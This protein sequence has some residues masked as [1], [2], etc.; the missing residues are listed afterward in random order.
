LGYYTVVAALLKAKTNPNG[1][2]LIAAAENNRRGIVQLLLESN[3]PKDFP[4]SSGMTAL[5]CA[6]AQG[7]DSIVSLLLEK[8]AD[9]ELRGR[10]DRTALLEAVIGGHTATVEALLR[11]GSDFKAQDIG[12]KTPVDWAIEKQLTPVLQLLA[13]SGETVPGHTGDGTN[14]LAKK[15]DLDVPPQ[16]P[17][18]ETS[19]TNFKFPELLPKLSKLYSMDGL[20]I[21][22][23]ITGLDHPFKAFDALKDENYDHM[24]QS[25]GFTTEFE[26]NPFKGGRPEPGNQ[27]YDLINSH[28]NKKINSIYAGLVR[29]YEQR[30]FAEKWQKVRSDVEKGQILSS[31][32]LS[33]KEDNHKVYLIVGIQIFQ[34][35]VVEFRDVGDDKASVSRK[36]GTVGPSKVGVEEPSNDEVGSDTRVQLP[37][38]HILAIKISEVKF[39]WKFLGSR[40][41]VRL[42]KPR[43]HSQLAAI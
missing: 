31:K 1:S 36:A 32:L 8:G 25:V 23:I 17:L 3:A 21:G 38:G 35:T 26:D 11:K 5:S 34:D 24:Y 39:N 2:A 40:L 33:A 42:E 30:G 18:K 22:Y 16:S 43:W 4:N 19:E 7:Y 15:S 6:A 41:S 9:P 27:L 10:S 20:N 37:G 13:A 28:K 14:T 29:T 12:G